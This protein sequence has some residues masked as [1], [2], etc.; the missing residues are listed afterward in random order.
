VPVFVT[1]IDSQRVNAGCR[2]AT[3]E[4]SQHWVA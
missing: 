3:E 1:S 2:G 4:R